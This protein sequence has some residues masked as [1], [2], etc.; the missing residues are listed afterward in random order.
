MKYV[1]F[2]CAVSFSLTLSAQIKIN[3]NG[4]NVTIKGKGSNT[5]KSNGTTEGTTNSTTNLSNDAYNFERNPDAPTTVNNNI[6]AGAFCVVIDSRRYLSR[7]RVYQVV[8]GGYAIIDANATD[9]DLKNNANA[10]RYFAA[11]SV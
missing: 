8:D 6:A 5:N 10:I 11:N 9:W 4:S 1:V 7:K 3:L 2:L